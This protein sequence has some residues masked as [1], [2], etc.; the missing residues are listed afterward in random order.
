M[1]VV[2][3]RNDY[4]KEIVRKRLRYG[5]FEDEFKFYDDIYLRGWDYDIY[6]IDKTL[7]GRYCLAPAKSCHCD[8]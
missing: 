7:G 6:E 8:L 1:F 4:S 2:I 3:R 5:G